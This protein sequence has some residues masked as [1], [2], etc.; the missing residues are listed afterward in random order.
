[1]FIGQASVRV[2]V[3]PFVCLAQDGVQN[4]LMMLSLLDRDGEDKNDLIETL[5]LSSML[6]GAGQNPFASM[7]GNPMT[8]M[9]LMNKEGGSIQNILMMQAMQG[10]LGNLFG[11]AAENKDQA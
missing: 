4:S 5:M 10:G 3:N 6:T 9:L 1:M 7:M 11:G 2:V 8:L